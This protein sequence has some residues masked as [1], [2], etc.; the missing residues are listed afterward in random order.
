[1]C[2]AQGGVKPGKAG[3]EIGGGKKNEWKK[4]ISEG[5]VRRGKA[6]F[7]KT[8]RAGHYRGVARDRTGFEASSR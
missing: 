7:E 5:L 6:S 4:G 1:M 2:G 3:E 8:K